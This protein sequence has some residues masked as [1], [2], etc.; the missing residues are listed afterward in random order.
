MNRWHDQMKWIDAQAPRLQ[1]QLVQLCAI[2]S[3]SW[4]VAGIERLQTALQPLLAPLGVPVERIALA[5]VQQLGKTGQIE[6]RPLAPA[7]RL[8]CRPEAPRQV[9][10]VGHLD[11]VFPADHPFQSHRL[12]D[13]NTLNAPGAADLKGGLLVMLTA[14]QAL[15]QSADKNNLG[16]EVILNPDEEI[17]SLGSA[18]LLAEAARRHHIGLCYEPS[19]PTGELVSTRKGTG[20][21]SVHVRGKAAHAGREHHLG[22]NA[23]VAAAHVASTLDALNGQHG[24]MTVNV[25]FVDGGGS[26]NVVPEHCLLKVNVR[27]SNTEQQRAFELALQAACAAVDQR[28][29]FKTTLLGSFHRPPKLMTPALESLLGLLRDCGNAINLDVRWQATGGCCD[30]NNLAAAGLA[31]VDNLG[32]RGGNIH[33]SDEFALL[34]SLTERAK[35]SALLLLRLAAGDIDFTPFHSANKQSHSS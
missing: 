12:L 33:S 25:G 21:F 27:V 22:R 18:P 26:V 14:L 30:G 13:A 9:L 35:L 8:R 20:T 7:L 24:D 16:W 31:N 32:V 1:Q 28:D 34:D 10:L 2:N 15:E 23:I 3:G 6:A 11:T 17:G 4:N 29:G 5:P 19:L